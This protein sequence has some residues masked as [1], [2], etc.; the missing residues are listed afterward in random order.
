MKAQKVSRDIATLFNP[1]GRRGWV[2]TAAPRAT[3]PQK[4]TRHPL[5]RE[6]GGTKGKY[7]RMRKPS[8]PPGFDP[9]TIQFLSESLYRLR[10]SGPLLLQ[11]QSIKFRSKRKYEQPFP[12]SSQTYE[13][14]ITQRCDPHLQWGCYLNLFVKHLVNG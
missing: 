2:A 12:C 14:Y 10:H 7:G 6:L 13:T 1:G 4:G 3:L 8:Q 9:R 5:H 11:R